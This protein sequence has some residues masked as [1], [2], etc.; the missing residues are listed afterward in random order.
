ML[1]RIKVT[2]VMSALDTDVIKTDV[3]LGLGIGIIASMAFQAERDAKLSLLDAGNIFEV[4]ATSIALRKRLLFAR[5]H[6]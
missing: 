1:S 5:L 6:L 4:N 2:I 3:E